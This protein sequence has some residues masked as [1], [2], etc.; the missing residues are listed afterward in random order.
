MLLWLGDFPPRPEPDGWTVMQR[1][2][3]TMGFRVF[4]PLVAA[5]PVLGVAAGSVAGMFSNFFLSRQ[6]VFRD[7]LPLTPA[8]KIQK[9]A[10]RESP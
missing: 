5:Y 8:G 3:Q 10:L 4:V 1:R 2:Y 7:E 6:I 9:A